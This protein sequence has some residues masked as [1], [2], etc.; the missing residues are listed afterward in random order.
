MSSTLLAVTEPESRQ[1]RKRRTRQALLDA[2]LDLL[3]DRAM[4]GL[5]L[6]EVTRAAGVVPTAFYRHFASMDDLGVALVEQ[7]MRT[8]R[9]VLR[10]ARRSGAAMITDS[11]AVLAEQVRAA[12]AHFRFLVRERPGGIPAVRAAIATELRLLAAELATDLGRLPVMAEWETDDLRMAADLMV[13][14]MLAT[15]MALV[16]AEEFDEP[17]VVDVAARQLRLIA[18]GIERWRPETP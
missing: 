15:V 14:A 17:E 6:R 11:V 12:P 4:T 9:A 8:L 1:D 5:S 13:S 3:A 16:E 10:R 18:L 7:C 2:A